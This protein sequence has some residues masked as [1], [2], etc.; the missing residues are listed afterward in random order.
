MPQSQWQVVNGEGQGKVKVVIFEGWCVGFRAWD[1]E[2]LRGKWEDA[3]RQKEQ[4]N[5]CGRLGHVKFED[6]RT[7]NG[8]LRKYDRLTGF[9]PP[10]LSVVVVVVMLTIKPSQLDALIHM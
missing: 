3:V 8:A 10:L 7:V 6:V 1:D 9:V 2:T 5:Y 4:G